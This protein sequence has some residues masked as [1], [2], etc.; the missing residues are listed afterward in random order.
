MPSLA[1][2]DCEESLFL[3][4]ITISCVQNTAALKYNDLA[5]EEVLTRIVWPDEGYD[6]GY[7]TAKV[8]LTLSIWEAP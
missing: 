7:F 6:T 1:S 8:Y 5:F 2:I 3:K 4:T